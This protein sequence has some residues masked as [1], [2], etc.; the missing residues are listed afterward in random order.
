MEQHKDE[1]VENRLLNLAFLNA[2]LGP[3]G[4]PWET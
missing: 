1:I 4:H 2:E 3:E